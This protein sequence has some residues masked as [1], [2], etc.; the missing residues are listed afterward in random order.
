M[1]QAERLVG[2]AGAVLVVDDTA[3]V[4][5]GWHS[6]GVPRQYCG[7]LG[8][9]ANCRVLVSLTRARG[10]VPVCVGLR[11]FV[12]EPWIAD[13][14]RCRR[15]G[16]PEGTVYR[17]KWRIA[18]DE[19]DRVIAAGATF[20]CVLADAAYGKV[21]AFRQG[22]SARGRLWAVGIRPTQKVY[23]AD[24]ILLA[25]T[26]KA[27]GRPKKH[28]TP[29]VASRSAADLF[30]ALPRAAFRRLSWRQGTKGPLRAAVAAVR[31]RVADGP[32]MTGGQ[33]LPGTEA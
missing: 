8:K 1:R 6:V 10:A 5:Q 12:P 15:A 13:P 31:V 9:R 11:L 21:A 28:P 25:P 2:G 18:L 20:G 3:L 33:P 22:L 23:P 4:K 14:K 7:Q 26:P 32:P 16:V 24:V 30:A 27:T 29:A 17:P 19:I